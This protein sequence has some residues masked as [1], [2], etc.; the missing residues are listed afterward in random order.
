[1]VRQYE[2]QLPAIISRYWYAIRWD[3]DAIWRL[4]LAVEST[5]AEL[6]A[7]HMVVPVWPDPSG[8]PYRV[9]PGEVLRQPHV[10]IREMQRILN[11]LLEYPIDMYRLQ[12]RLM[13]L[14]GIHRLARACLGLHIDYLTVD[15]AAGFRPPIR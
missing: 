10:H 11:A 3:V 1:M 12:K 9:T 8:E 4:D 15:H 14:D 13:N 5:P 6:L 2:L 7:W